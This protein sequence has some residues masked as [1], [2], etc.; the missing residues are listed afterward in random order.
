MIWSEQGGCSLWPSVW[1]HITPHF[2]PSY[3]RWFEHN[4]AP[5]APLSP[6]VL[7]SDIPTDTLTPSSAPPPSTSEWSLIT[8]HGLYDEMPLAHLTSSCRLPLTSS[9]HCTLFVCQPVYCP[10]YAVMCRFTY[11]ITF[12]GVLTALCTLLFVV[13]K[14]ETKSNL[15]SSAVNCP[16]MLKWMILIAV[17][18][19]MTH[20]KPERGVS[21]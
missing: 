18:N 6:S 5:T 12:F 11:G 17:W 4:L 20:S 9:V 3:P 13:I 15:F 8:V 16:C 7:L 21:N 1:S 2:S 14:R 19:L 10:Y